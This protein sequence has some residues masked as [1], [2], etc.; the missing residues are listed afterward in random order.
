MIIIT[1]ALINMILK[2][3]LLTRSGWN[4]KATCR[5]LETVLPL[6]TTIFNKKRERVLS[7]SSPDGRYVTR[8]GW[9][10]LSAHTSP[11]LGPSREAPGGGDA[12]AEGAEEGYEHLAGCDCRLRSRRARTGFMR[13]PSIE[14]TR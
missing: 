11:P 5:V 10:T 1:I 14:N 13:F 12:I 2:L 4:Q 7:S 8:A 9:K 6:R 3:I